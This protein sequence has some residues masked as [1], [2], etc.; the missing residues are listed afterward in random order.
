MATA[1]P[2]FEATVRKIHSPQAALLVC[3][4]ALLTTQQQYIARFDA[5]GL[6][7]CAA[8]GLLGTECSH[9]VSL[10]VNLKASLRQAFAKQALQGG[11][12]A[13]TAVLC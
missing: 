11:A 5:C 10:V 2:D 7:G 8:W 13:A 12:V 4:L 6:V 9:T 3:V 1:L